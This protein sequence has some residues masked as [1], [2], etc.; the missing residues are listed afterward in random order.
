VDQVYWWK[1]YSPPRW[2]LNGR[3]KEITTFDLMGLAGDQMIDVLKIDAACI[4][5]N[6]NGTVLV[7]PASATFLDPYTAPRFAGEE[8]ELVFVELWR[9]RQHIGLDDLD[10]GDDGVWPTLERVVGRRGLVAWDVR[11]AC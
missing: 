5:G 10:F 7:A 9:Y 2:L 3:N 4:G 1:T 8:P 6:E 11:R